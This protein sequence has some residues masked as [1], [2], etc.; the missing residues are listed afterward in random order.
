MVGLFAF[1]LYAQNTME[2]TIHQFTVKTL[3]GDQFDFSSLKG[4]KL[5]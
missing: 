1:T 2:K 4:K 3:E 5:W